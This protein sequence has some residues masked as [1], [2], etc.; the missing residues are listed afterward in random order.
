MVF[1]LLFA[2]FLTTFGCDFLEKFILKKANIFFKQFLE[3]Q[4]SKNMRPIVLLGVLVALLI[5]LFWGCGTYNSFVKKEVGVEKAWGNVQNAYQRR[6]DL[7]GN[8]VETVKGQANYEK[9][10]LES[11]V[12]ARASATSIN[13]DPS[14]L[15]SANLEKFKAAQSQLS[16]SLSR[17][18]MTVEKYPELKANAA[19]SEL[20]AEIAGT[21]NR[22]KVSRD[23]FNEAVSEYNV[24]VRQ[25]PSAVVANITGFSEKV[26]F[27]S[28]AGSDKAPDLKGA[29]D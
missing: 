20:R 29:F 28:E 15:T 1:N 27:E 24:N 6:T 25:M 19:F 16:G 8:L 26:M 17:L 4:N 12:K 23:R 10:T 3:K 9:S 11:V 5:A 14:N 13:I 21:E 22:I 2:F 18:M 7:I